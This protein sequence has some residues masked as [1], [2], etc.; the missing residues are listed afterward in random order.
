LAQ[1]FEG[2]Y[3]TIDLV[4]TLADPQT[5]PSDLRATIL[6]GGGADVFIAEPSVLG[7]LA[8]EGL[9]TPLDATRLAGAAD[10]LPNSA[11]EVGTWNRRL[12]GYP[13]LLHA[14][15]LYVN[16]A[17]VSE[18][19]TTFDEFIAA[20]RTHG[21]L[22]TPTFNV[23][24]AWLSTEGRVITP[25]NRDD[26]GATPSAFQS[27][28]ERMATLKTTANITFSADDRAFR[29]GEVGLYVGDSRQW[30]TLSAA[31]GE[32]LAVRPL[33]I[34]VREAGYYLMQA[35]M[36]MVSLNATSADLAAATEWMIFIT[37]PQ[38]QTTLSRLSGY[39]PLLPDFTEV[40]SGKEAA[41]AIR[42][43]YPLPSE[44]LFYT[45]T[46]PRFEAALQAVLNDELAPSEALNLAFP[47]P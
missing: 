3:P 23:T 7:S 13:F 27:Y 4:L 36:L 33:F 11:Y 42:M 34:S 18:P 37:R 46:L 12:F 2:L 25:G 14:P 1:T 10:S 29:A 47:Q 44:S 30:G 32:S 6:S 45:Q 41:S 35:Q 20:A 26:L 8:Q 43:A 15:V 19:P 17:L 39:P 24:G 40:Q 31:L 9:L 5:F 38:A 21:A 22:I 28:L 16:T